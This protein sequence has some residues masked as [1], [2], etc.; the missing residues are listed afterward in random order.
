MHVL[1]MH[2]IGLK[3]KRACRD[4]KSAAVKNWVSRLAW[5]FSIRFQANFARVRV[6]TWYKVSDKV[7]HL[8]SRKLWSH[9]RGDN[10]GT[11]QH[12]GIIASIH[13]QISSD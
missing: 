5:I 10:A 1:Y 2:K 11:P 4:L 3:C 12:N 13:L 8:W 7:E 9:V 6:R